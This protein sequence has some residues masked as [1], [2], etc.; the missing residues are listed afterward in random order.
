MLKNTPVSIRT[1]L[2][3]ADVEFNLGRRMDYIEL[4]P[5]TRTKYF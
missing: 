1:D 4:Q 2:R 3:Y 5:G